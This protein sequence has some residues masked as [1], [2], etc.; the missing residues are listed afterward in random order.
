MGTCVLNA[1]ICDPPRVF[2]YRVS[3]CI[4]VTCV[5]GS[6]LCDTLSHLSL[7]N[8]HYCIL[9]VYAITSKGSVHRQ[10]GAIVWIVR[11]R[12]WHKH[13]PHYRLC[14]F[15]IIHLTVLLL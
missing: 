4:H 11:I 2:L 8:H 5:F 13:S 3:R 15:V 14:N 7:L 6:D 10:Q 12:E 1:H 9:L